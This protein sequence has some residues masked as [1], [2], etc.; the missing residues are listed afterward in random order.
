MTLTP[1]RLML[2]AVLLV[3]GGCK[4]N[5]PQVDTVRRLIPLG[6]SKQETLAP[7]AWSL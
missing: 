3:I 7:Y 5:T 4:L 6:D 1:L 2:I